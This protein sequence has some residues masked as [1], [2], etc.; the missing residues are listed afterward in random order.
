MSRFGTQA[1][2]CSQISGRGPSPS[3]KEE[4]AKAAAKVGYVDR[5]RAMCAIV[6]LGSIS[7]GDL[8]PGAML[9][10]KGAVR[11]GSA[12]QKTPYADEIASYMQK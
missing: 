1:L 9:A 8:V 2:C 5:I 11:T 6:G 12:F 10:A 4:D 3:S 7:V